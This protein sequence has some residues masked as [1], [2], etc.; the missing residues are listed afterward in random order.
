MKRHIR[1]L[2]VGATIAI[3]A[4]I[5]SYLPLTFTGRYEP[6]GIGLSGVKFYSW[7]PRG[8]VDNFRWDKKRIYLYLPLIALDI[9]LWHTSDK[10]LSDKYPINKVH[11]D[12]IWKVY[13]AW[14]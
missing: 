3:A 5:I 1:R 9:Y 8:F 4:Y 7:A 13:K 14:D 11:P 2:K 6:A 10:A 12:D